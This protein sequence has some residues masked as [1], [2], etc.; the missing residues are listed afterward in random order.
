MFVIEENLECIKQMCQSAEWHFQHSSSWYWPD[1]LIIVIAATIV[2]KKKYL[3][4]AIFIYI[5]TG[6]F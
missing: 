2:I 4:P 3:L 6:I 5:V 1:I